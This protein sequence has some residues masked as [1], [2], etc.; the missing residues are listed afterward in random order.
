MAGL[1]RL[2]EIYV[3]TFPLMATTFLITFLLCKK[4]KIPRFSLVSAL[5]DT[6]KPTETIKLMLNYLNNKTS[7]RRYQHKFINATLTNSTVL[8]K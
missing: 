6:K 4:N 1:T 7:Y 3:V 2:A 8:L 5:Y